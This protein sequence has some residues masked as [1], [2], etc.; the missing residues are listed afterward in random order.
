MTGWL[1]AADA[2]PRRRVLA[3]ATMMLPLAATASCSVPDLLAPPPGPSVSVRTLTAAIAAEESLVHT[4]QQVIA[5]QPDLG[6]QLHPFL[7]QHQDHLAQLKN[8][9]V[10]PPHVRTPSAAPATS[11]PPSPAPTSA[12]AALT[13]LGQAEQSAAAAQLERLGRVP[14]SLAQLLA[15]IAASEV[16]H[17]V[18][19]SGLTGANQGGGG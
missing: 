12:S 4:Y 8:R 18:A 5:R 19:L 6:A 16:T 13:L 15:S 14:P 9:L 2:V 3:A 1:A 7:T 11:G 17:A 10:V